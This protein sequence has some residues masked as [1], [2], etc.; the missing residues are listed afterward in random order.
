MPAQAPADHGTGWVLKVAAIATLAFCG[1]EL[2]GGFYSNS[3]AVVADGWHNFS[4]GAAL[5]LGWLAGYARSRAPSRKRTYGY[6][7]ASVLAAFAAALSL[8]LVT[9]ILLYFGY[10]RLLAPQSPRTTWMLVFGGASLALNAAISLALRRRTSSPAPRHVLARM[11]GDALAAVCMM[12][13]AVAIALTGMV[14]LDTILAFL[15]AGLIVW[16]TWEIVIDSL[17]TLLEALPRG[18]NLD[19]VVAAIRGIEGVED[20][21]DVHVWTLG[22]D[23]HALSCHVRIPELPIPDGEEIVRRISAAVEEQFGIRHT[24]VQVEDA[25]CD[26]VHGCVMTGPEPAHG[27]HHPH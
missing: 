2:A 18:M 7:R 27:Q 10:Q 24:T 25:A 19:Q 13:A 9:G 22:P 6:G 4:D 5:L 3:L 1:L 8:L 11:A 26:S 15:I 20:V 16:T 14:L 12:A 17:N 21:H 23:S